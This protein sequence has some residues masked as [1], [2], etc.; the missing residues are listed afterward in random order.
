[1]P[2]PLYDALFAPLIGRQSPFLILPDG[3]TGW[4]P[5]W[6]LSFESSDDAA[7]VGLIDQLQNAPKTYTVVSGD[8]LSKIA[9]AKGTTVTALKALNGLSGDLILVGQVLHLPQG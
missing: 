4:V 8:S 3:T 6:Y 1:M 7:V 2:N 9:K 5:S